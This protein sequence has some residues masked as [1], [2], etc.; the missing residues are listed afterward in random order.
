M[1]SAQSL[2]SYGP[3]EAYAQA[4][5]VGIFPHECMHHVNQW[6]HKGPGKAK[7]LR[8][9]VVNRDSSLSLLFP[10]TLPSTSHTE[11]AVNPLWFGSQAAMHWLRALTYPLC[12]SVSPSLE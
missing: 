2:A 11:I 1:L 12:A 10:S 9:Q 6:G 3:P 4:R 8:R 5:D 7:P